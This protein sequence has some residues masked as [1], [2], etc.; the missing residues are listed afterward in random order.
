MG[1]QQL[2]LV[3]LVTVI[4]GIASTVA[5]QVFSSMADEANK[6]AARQDMVTIAA[7]AQAFFHKPTALGGGSSDFTSM[8]F[9]SIAFAYDS[10]SA[11]GLTAYNGN[12]TY[13]ME[14]LSATAVCLNSVPTSDDTESMH[15]DIYDSDLL[16]YDTH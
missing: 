7:N 8:T 6:D 4:V 16:W 3:I 2:L 10:L 12:G 14:F 15:L 11:D 13:T 9:N 5:I 1:Q